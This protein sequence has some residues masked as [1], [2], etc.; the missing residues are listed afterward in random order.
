VEL[1]SSAKDGPCDT[2]TLGDNIRIYVLERFGS[3][4]ALSIELI[5][6]WES[7]HKLFEFLV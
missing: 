5:E 6:E 2:V 1:A 7:G 4:S 3:F